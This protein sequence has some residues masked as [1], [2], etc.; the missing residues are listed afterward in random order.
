MNKLKTW[1]LI[2]NHLIVCDQDYIYQIDLDGKLINRVSIQEEKR[3][4]LSNV[5][6]DDNN[7]FYFITTDGVTKYNAKSEKFEI[8]LKKNFYRMSFTRINNFQIKYLPKK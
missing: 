5:E 6:M 2:N 4:P 8:I 3:N 7:N 1:S